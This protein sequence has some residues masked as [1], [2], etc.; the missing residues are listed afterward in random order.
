RS[1]RGRSRKSPR[2]CARA[3][4]RSIPRFAA[5]AFSAATTRRRTNSGRAGPRTHRKP[6]DM[7]NTRRWAV[8]RIARTFGDASVKLAIAASA[9]FTTSVFAQSPAPAAGSAAIRAIAFGG[10]DG[11]ANDADGAQMEGLS[12]KLEELGKRLESE[13]DT[14]RSM[15]QAKERWHLAGEDA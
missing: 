7:E 5:K 2:D 6:T 8:S 14:D 12:K 15:R 4:P 1:R 3:S 9:L 13:L 11:D 10:D